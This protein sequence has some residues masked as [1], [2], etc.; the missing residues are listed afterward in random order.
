MLKP[1]DSE[2]WRLA[3]YYVLQGANHCMNLIEHARVHFPS[4]AINA[5]T[6]TALPKSHIVFKLL[7][8]HARLSLGV[9]NSVL[10]GAGSLINRTTWTIY[11]PFAAPGIEVRRLLPFAWHGK[12]GNGAYRPFVYPREPRDMPTRY[13]VFLRKYYDVIYE[14]VSNE[15]RHHFG[16]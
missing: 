10:E 15:I 7:N 8:P 14:F 11:S 13:G 6:A 3:K 1:E 5:V 9:N 2:R 16:D 4:D 12:A